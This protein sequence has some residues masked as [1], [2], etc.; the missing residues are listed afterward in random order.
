MKVAIDPKVLAYA[1][2]VN[3][4][5]KRD[6]VIELLRNLP[7]EAAVIPVQ[8]LGELFN[9]L[10]RK[11]GRHSQEARDKLLSWSDAFAVAG[12]TP[13]VMMKAVDLAA[14]H[15]FGIWDAV[16]LSTASQTG[17]R[18]LLSEDLQDGFTWGGV[19]VVNP[20]ASPRHALLDALLGAE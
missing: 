9:V 11:A 14:D 16:I 7:R 2:G 4:A 10:V 17:C 15:R 12:T 6:V 8:V 3:N 13:E 20:F 5:E 18:L 19:T 1:E